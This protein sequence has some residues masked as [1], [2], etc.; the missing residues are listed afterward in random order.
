MIRNQIQGRADEVRGQEVIGKVTGNT[1]TEY[2]GKA[3][4]H[5]GRTQAARGA[6]KRDFKRAAK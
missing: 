4:K 2:E 3:E 1:C 5:G 6:V